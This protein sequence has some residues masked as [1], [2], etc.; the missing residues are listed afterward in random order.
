MLRSQTL[1]RWWPTTQSLDLVHGTVRQVAAAVE[2]EVT[3]FVGGETLAT[4]WSRYADLD[5]AF[6]AVAEFA[7]VPTHFLVLPTNS[8]WTVLWNNSF[9]CSGYDALCACLTKNHGLTSIH[10][11]AHDSTTVFQPGAL[12]TH[13]RLVDTAVVERSVHVTRQD[14]KWSFGEAGPV[15]PQENT[16]S[17]L[18]RRVHDRLNESLMAALLGRLGAAPWTEEFYALAEQSCFVLQRPSAPKTVIRRPRDAVVGF[19]RG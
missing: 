6:G 19:T 15:L 7:N 17:Y 18:A 5:E 2:A 9:L 13:R 16:D 1:E 4:A 3:R 14:S 11:S 8:E 12:F 10:W